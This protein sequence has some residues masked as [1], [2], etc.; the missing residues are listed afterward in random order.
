MS[1]FCINCGTQLS[2]EVNF[3]N[4]CGAN[5]SGFNASK[6]SVAENPE[7]KSNNKVV[8]FVKNAPLFMSGLIMSLLTWPIYL[9]F[10]LIIR[11]PG[12]VYSSI[13]E[14]QVYNEM[15][16]WDN[17]IS[18]SETLGVFGCIGVIA[19]VLGLV[20][21]IIETKGIIRK[22][23][24]RNICLFAIPTITII[25]IAICTYPAIFDYETTFSYLRR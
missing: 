22:S 19:L 4:N 7:D 3:C 9:W 14:W 18:S 15:I 23:K 6:M 10:E 11:L 24:L 25:I 2:D 8:I 1:K 17:A 20:L 16:V 13:K 5:I 21:Y 12:A